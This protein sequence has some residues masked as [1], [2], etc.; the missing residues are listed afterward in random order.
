MCST[1]LLAINPI[2]FFQAIQNQDAKSLPNINT[3]ALSPVSNRGL[4][5]TPNS[6]SK[7]TC[8]DGL[9]PNNNNLILQ[10]KNLNEAL[11]N[12]PKIHSLST[13]MLTG[14]PGQPPMMNRQLSDPHLGIQK[15]SDGMFSHQNR[16]RPVYQRKEMPRGPTRTPVYLR[17]GQNIPELFVSAVNFKPIVEDATDGQDEEVVANLGNGNYLE[18]NDSF[19][20]DD[21][22]VT[23][24]SVNV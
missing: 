3:C 7:R 16:R 19:S 9:L 10:P 1:L 22:V 21:I 14:F 13:E 12:Q 23:M 17:P 20:R 15:A 2:Y 4:S 18:S 24:R 6:G 11:L 8:K 5:I